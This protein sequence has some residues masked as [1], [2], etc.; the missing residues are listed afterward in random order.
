MSDE[1]EGWWKG[2]ALDQGTHE[3]INARFYP[4][5]RQLCVLCDQP[6][7]RCEEDTIELDDGTSPVCE[8]CRDERRRTDAGL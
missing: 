3:R 1:K 2:K 5:T 8:T 4:G 6:T 7:G